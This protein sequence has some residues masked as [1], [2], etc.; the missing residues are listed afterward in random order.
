LCATLQ[1]TRRKTLED[2]SSCSGVLTVVQCSGSASVPDQCACPV[3]VNEAR[4]EKVKA[5]QDAYD[6]WVK[7][8]CGPFPCG[9]A[10]FAGT[11]GKCDS[12]SGTCQW[13]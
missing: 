5:A 7:A 6:A 12:V 4:P 10:C 2:A 3:I 1:E 11:K 9:A 8:G 13:E